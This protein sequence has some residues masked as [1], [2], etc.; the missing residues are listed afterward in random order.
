[1]NDKNNMNL[2]WDT[3]TWL[4]EGQHVFPDFISAKNFADDNNIIC[5]TTKQ[6]SVI[7]DTAHNALLYERAWIIADCS[8]PFE[9]A[10][11]EATSLETKRKR[12]LSKLTQEERSILG[13]LDDI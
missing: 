10:T 2:R 13:L 8:G 12:A 4:E 9:F 1:M 5:P 3:G 7:V 6:V 11:Y